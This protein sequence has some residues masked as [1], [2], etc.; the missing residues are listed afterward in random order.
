VRRLF[1]PTLHAPTDQPAKLYESGTDQKRQNHPDEEPAKSKQ[2]GRKQKSRR[3]DPWIPTHEDDQK[4]R[5]H[6]L[7][8]QPQRSSQTPQLKAQGQQGIL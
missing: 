1:D 2:Q 3:L 8:K 5:N 4:Q 7:K 6:Q